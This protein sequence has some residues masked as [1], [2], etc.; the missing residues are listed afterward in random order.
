VKFTEY[1][2]SVDEKAAE[3]MIRVSGQMGVPVTV[4]DGQV[5]VGFDRGRLQA[6][7]AGG[8]I[9]FGLKVADA[10]RIAPKQGAV[11]VFGA[12]IGAVAAGSLGE[13]AGLKAGDIITEISGRRVNN[14]ADVEQVLG[15]LRSG[16]VMTILF[17]R[18]EE[19]RKS[20]IV[21]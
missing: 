20:E 16:S 2:V 18:G 7:L 1:D 13:K 21:V 5:V 9:H 11:P 19:T 6:L 14:A 10:D 8:K 15:G 12:V 3:E 4:I 17:L